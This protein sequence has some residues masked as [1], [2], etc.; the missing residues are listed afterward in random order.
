MLVS[1]IR[2]GSPADEAEIFRGY[3]IRYVDNR[4]VIDL[5]QFKNIYEK[6]KDISEP[7]RMLKLTYKDALIFALLREE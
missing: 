6:T 7:G 4:E 2:A 3:V 1:G 5:E